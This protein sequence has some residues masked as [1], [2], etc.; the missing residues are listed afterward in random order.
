MQTLV[1][2]M[3]KR[4]RTSQQENTVSRKWISRGLKALEK[5]F[6]Y[7]TLTRHWLE[8]LFG[9]G[10]D[11]IRAGQKENNALLLCVKGGAQY[12]G[13][14][15]WE[16]KLANRCLS[17]FR[18]KG[19]ILVLSSCLNFV[20][21]SALLVFCSI[22]KESILDLK[23]LVQN[24]PKPVE[25]CT[26]SDVELICEEVWVVSAAEPRLPLQIDDASRPETDNVSWVWIWWQFLWPDK[27][28]KVLFWFV[29]MNRLKTVWA[30]LIKTLVL[31]TV[32]WI[33]VRQRIKPS[34]ALKL[35]CVSSS[36]NRWTTE[37]VEMTFGW[38]FHDKRVCNN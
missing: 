21:Y 11:C 19:I 31:I 3:R 28:I 33:Y 6:E 27:I 36:G 4:R 25:S 5:W 34:I 2:L 22:S 17:L 20:I 13:F 29:N 30:R 1:E 37:W 14:W 23:G 12:R 9:S 35:L 18:S 10:L 26:Q 32:S 15:M 38:N 8:N 16:K 24:V 7:L